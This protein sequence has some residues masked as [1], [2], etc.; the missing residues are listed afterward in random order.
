[1]VLLVACKVV[2]VV[3]VQTKGNELTWKE[4]LKAHFIISTIIIIMIPI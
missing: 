2:A 4:T 3:V 1:M